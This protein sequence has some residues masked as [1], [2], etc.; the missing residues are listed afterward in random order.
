VASCALGPTRAGPGLPRHR[1]A[2]ASASGA[3]GAALTDQRQRDIADAL[4][5][6]AAEELTRKA[7]LSRGNSNRSDATG[8][9]RE[10]RIVK[11]NGNTVDVVSELL[12]CAWW[13]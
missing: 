13:S 7:A 5:A 2:L 11:I 10:R 8:T 12:L 6:L 9:A 4:G 1:P 3:A